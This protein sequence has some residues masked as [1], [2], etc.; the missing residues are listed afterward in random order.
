MEGVAPYIC[1]AIYDWAETHT[2]VRDMWRNNPN[3]CAAGHPLM[4]SLKRSVE[5]ER[6]HHLGA[7]HV[8]FSHGLQC[9]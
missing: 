9:A 2:L 8:S 3:H 1:I 4:S 6:I 7:L 5:L